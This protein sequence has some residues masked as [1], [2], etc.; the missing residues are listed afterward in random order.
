MDG[1]EDEA[2]T[3]LEEQEPKGWR[4]LCAELQTETDPNRF[5][6]LVAQINRLLNAHEKA[7]RQEDSA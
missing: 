4:E 1:E 3:Y 7:D 2:M 5:R 6:V